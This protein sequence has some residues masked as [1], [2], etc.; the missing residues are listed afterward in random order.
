MQISDS[1]RPVSHP[2][3]PKLKKK[4]DF[5]KVMIKRWLKLLKDIPT[6]DLLDLY[7]QIS[8]KGKIRKQ[9]IP[10]YSQKCYLHM[11]E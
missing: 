7:D 2:K 11:L 8:P 1:K 9:T 3:R 5:T 4:Q 6:K 10:E